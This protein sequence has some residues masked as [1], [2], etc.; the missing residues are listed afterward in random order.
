MGNDEAFAPTLLAA[1]AIGPV[2]ISMV[3]NTS[4]TN[5]SWY[6]VYGTNLIAK[7][8]T[9]AADKQLYID[10]TAGRADDA[11]VTGDMILGASTNDA[12]ATN[13]CSV[14]IS[15]PFVTDALG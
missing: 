6:Q 1:N 14:R 2:A 8:D 15:Y 7:T 3:A 5:Y 10:G 11:V 4:A 12:D 13:V 9:V